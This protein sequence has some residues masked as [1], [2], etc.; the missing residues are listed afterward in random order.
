M[1][2]QPLA[3]SRRGRLFRRYFLFIMALVCGALLASGAI[4][5]YASY[6]ENKAG[7]ARL[8]KEKAV[9][10]AARIEQFVKGIEQQLTFA[11]LPQL[12]SEGAEQRRIEFLK[13]LRQAPA[14]TDIVQLDARGQEV[15][16]VSRLSMDTAGAS[17]DRAAD[18]AFL[19][20][21][22]GKPWIGPVYFRKETEPYFSVGLRSGGAAG[23]VTV[24]EVNLK[25]VWD[26]VSRIR[27]GDKGKAYVV[28]ARGQLVADPDIGLVLRKTDLS[29]L[30]HVKAALGGKEEN[31]TA[32]LARTLSG[33]EVLTAWSAIET[34]GW[35]VFV[36][37]PVAEV[38]A[39]LNASIVRTILLLLIGLVV[40][41]V[42]STFLARSM[43][44]PIR[45]LQDGA[46]RIGEG[47]LDQ[48][49]EIKTNDELESLAE[50][51][52]QMTAQLR[53]SYAGLER[54]VD[55]RTSELRESLEQQTATSEIL[56]VISS[57][58][59]SEQPVFDA[60]VASA[61]R[62]F[63]DK[64]FGLEIVVDGQL[65]IKAVALAPDGVVD[66][67][68]V[69][70]LYPIPV[71]ASSTTGQA[72]LESR[73]VRVFDTEAEGAPAGSRMAGRAFGYR[74][75]T[76]VPL[77]REGRAIGAI[78]MASRKTGGSLSPKQEALIQTFAD[79][80]VIAIENA[81]LFDEVQ[82]RT[83]EVEE[84]LEY[85]TAISEVLRVI[86]ESP[87]DVTPVFRTILE[88]AQRLF[89]QPMT[90]VFLYD[91]TNVDMVATINWPEKALEDAK[92][93]YPAPPHPQMISGR[94]ILGGTVLSI[95]DTLADPE[96][97]KVTAS[98]GHWRRMLGA[99]MIRDGATVGAIVVC[100]R[101][102]GKTPQRQADLLKTFA[103]Q[104]VIA[105]ENVRLLTE[106]REALDRQTAI[107]DILRAIS[108]SVT[109][110]K[111]ILDVVVTRAAQICGAR[112][113]HI[114]LVEGERLVQAAVYGDLTRVEVP[115]TLPLV[116]GTAPGRAVLDLQVIHI[117]D[118]ALVSDD[119]YPISR[120]LHQKF[121]HRSM[122]C[123]PLLREGAALGVIAMRRTEAGGFTDN[124]VALMRA[125]A[126]QA[127]IAIANTRLFEEIQEK[128]RQL[129]LAN[130]HK[131]DFL[132][133]M[134][135]ELRTPLNAVIGFS[136]VLIEG[137]FG[138]LNEKQLDYTQDIHSSG[139][140]LLSLINDILDLS[141]I[142]AGRMEL[143]VTTFD[144]PSALGNAVT[145]VRERAL[146]HGIDLKMAVDETLGEYVG[147]ERKFKQIMLNLLSNAVKFTG[148]GGRVT[149]AAHRAGEDIEVSVSDSG[150]GI[151]PEDQPRVF[152]EFVQVG[153]NYATKREGTG[154][155]LP[156]ARRFVELHGGRMWLESVPGEGSTFFFNLPVK[157]GETA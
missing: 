13:L 65:H 16:A 128:G 61:Q 112:D 62:L 68:A 36:E 27:V 117:P 21:K 5:L 152:E 150:I 143:E 76:A 124:Q 121:G 26:V 147:D 138:D 139:K 125:F 142:E 84:S 35:E 10:A 95:E 135:H 40:S 105:I 18:P 33:A 92:R 131:S 97:E 140:H 99:P 137:M 4:S 12:G 119:E 29:S 100:W 136:E 81:R 91:G 39:T 6:Q 1:S 54:K 73:V 72:I 17:K 113:A 155:G 55:E 108:D 85:Q 74:E 98:A 104:A 123:V 30:T 48:R 141:K 25:F 67:A 149:V 2:S 156:L 42:V 14:V 126:D 53:E 101:K 41:A 69:R 31:E 132:A 109:D 145:L 11:A 70:R 32:L 86:S 19:N 88:S 151:T 60:I 80:A 107:A 83:R 49:I 116:R 15:L 47:E 57:S 146:R 157:S 133:N 66:E 115:E 122:L 102:P 24:A 93:H 63:P 148:D 9:A 96:Y 120:E 44:R 134:S 51:F 38:Y 52:N 114:F 106:T 8:Q 129:Q 23:G 46:Q 43:V 28:D 58:P 20:A 22:P 111:P 37:Q 127:A 45:V 75:I 94:V 34:L 103:D 56:R 118:L 110:F 71:D 87:T 153:S 89:D 144:L 59:T 90:A 78:G 7:L 77:L 130:Q 64:G 82:A 154:L 3:G 50:Q 79:Q